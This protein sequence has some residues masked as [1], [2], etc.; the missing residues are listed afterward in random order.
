M[1]SYL[2]NLSLLLISH[3]V[4]SA[5]YILSKFLM[6]HVST[7]MLVFFRF[8][9]GPLLLLPFFLSQKIKL[10]FE[11]PVLL[12]IR[13]LSGLSSL[14]FYFFAIKYGEIGR[15]TLISQ[16][17]VIWTIFI[18]I[19]LFKEKPSFFV[20]LAIP[21]AFLGLFLV[22]SPSMDFSLH[23]GDI[24]A[25]LGSIL[26]AIS[27][28]TTKVLRKTHSAL[29]LVFTFYGFSA[30]SSG[31]FM[32][33]YPVNLPQ[34]LTLIFLILVGLFSFLGQLGLTIGFKYLPAATASG[35]NLIVVPLNYIAGLLFFNESLNFI[36]FLGIVLVFSSLLVIALYGNSSSKKS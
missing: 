15:S 7:S 9:I 34:F 21:M 13:C 14:V 35:I 36:S 23:K 16:L 22:F 27:W 4:L 2:F 30:I 10:Q 17:S 32:S 18:S 5:S 25:F 31:L 20:K 3:C 19:F 1:K 33:F 28:S 29:G 26:V 12:T 24:F 8:C 6:P 11:N